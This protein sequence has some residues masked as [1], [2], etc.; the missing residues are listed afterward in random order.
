M[1]DD[2]VQGMRHLTRVDFA[3]AMLRF[4]LLHRSEHMNR[5]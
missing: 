3:I 4:T 5:W 1:L 2:Y